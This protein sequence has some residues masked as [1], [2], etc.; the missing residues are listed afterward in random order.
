VGHHLITCCVVFSVALVSC[1]EPFSG[2]TDLGQ[3]KKAGGKGEPILG[4]GF[5]KTKTKMADNTVEL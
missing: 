4:V 2:F 1:R 3:Y 5:N